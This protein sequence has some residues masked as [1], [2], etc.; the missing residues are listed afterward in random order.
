M[1]ATA[2]FDSSGCTL[3]E[4]VCLLSETTAAVEK[5]RQVRDRLLQK[6]HD[7]PDVEAAQALLAP[8]AEN[9]PQNE[10]LRQLRR[11]ILSNKRFEFGASLDNSIGMK[12]VYIPAGRFLMGSPL[13]EPGRRAGE[14]EHLVTLSCGFFMGACEVTRAQWQRV[15]QPYQAQGL[16]DA[17]RP[18]TNVSWEQV[19]QFCRAL[20]QMESGRTYRLPTEAEWEYACRAGTRTA[21]NTGRCFP[22]RGRPFCS[23]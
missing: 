15:M 12:L 2:M 20:S 10:T 8:Y 14:S 17:D 3:P 19:R 11:T 6:I 4:K 13:T 1:L 22:R 16:P 23:I 7:A 18:Q 21:F 5:V 9:A